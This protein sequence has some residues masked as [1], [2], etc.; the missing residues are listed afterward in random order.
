[1]PDDG[2][3]RTIDMADTGLGL[4]QGRHRGVMTGVKRGMACTI[5]EDMSGLMTGQGNTIDEGIGPVVTLTMTDEGEDMMETNV[6]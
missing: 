6:G 4:G 2:V 3:K 1:M 5:T